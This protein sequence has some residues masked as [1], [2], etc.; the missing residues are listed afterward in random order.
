M[1][2]IVEVTAPIGQMSARFEYSIYILTSDYT[3]K[4]QAEEVAKVYRGLGCK[5]RIL[6]ETRTVEVEE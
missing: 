2:Y 4:D 6:K 5:V 1:S 3:F